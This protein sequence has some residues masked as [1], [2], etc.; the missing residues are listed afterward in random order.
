MEKEIDF[1]QGKPDGEGVVSN[2]GAQAVVQ[3][4]ASES[5]KEL[6]ESP[7]AIAEELCALRQ[8]M[9][10]DAEREKR[11]V[12]YFKSKKDRGAQL[13]G[14]VMVKVTEEKGRK[15]TDWKAYIMGSEGAEG[16]AEAE[17]KYTKVGEPIIK[18]NVERIG[19]GQQG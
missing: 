8:R 12:S 7:E 14:S 18:V 1:T 9:K 4:F 11:L 2:P 6:E 10:V 17:Q 15:S 19:P 13:Y 3:H 5:L 16:V